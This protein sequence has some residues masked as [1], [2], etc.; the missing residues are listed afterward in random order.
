MH[1]WLVCVGV[2]LSRRDFIVGLA[3][4]GVL[5]GCQPAKSEEPT[6]FE[7]LEDRYQALIG[8]YA[9]D[10]ESSATVE[11]RADERFAICSTFKAYAAARILQMAKAGHANLDAMVPI[12]SADIARR[13][14]C[15]STNDSGELLLGRAAAGDEFIS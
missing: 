3:A 6:S 9:V 7:D 4:T 10:L 8:V 15:R 14:T 2:Q 5:A 13:S 12:T 11:H 1:D